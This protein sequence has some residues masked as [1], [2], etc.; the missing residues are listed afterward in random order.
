MSQFVTFIFLLCHISSHSNS[1]GCLNNSDLNL[2]SCH[3][4][5]LVKYFS[6]LARQELCHQ[7]YNSHLLSFFLV[8]SFPHFYFKLRVACSLL[9]MLSYLFICNSRTVLSL[10]TSLCTW[11]TRLPKGKKGMGMR[12]EYSEYKAN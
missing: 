4:Y 2:Y 12:Q 1:I 10:K 6:Q 8:L 11:E 9:L 7:L 5:P 3:V